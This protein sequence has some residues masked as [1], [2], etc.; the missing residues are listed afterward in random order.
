MVN[1]EIRPLLGLGLP[2]QKIEVSSMHHD[3]K[4]QQRPL[5]ERGSSIDLSFSTIMSV[6]A[7]RQRDAHDALNDAV[8]AGLAL[9]KLQQLLRAA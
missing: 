4:N 7:L 9:L 2:Q 8:M 1:R 5:H 3:V 6:L